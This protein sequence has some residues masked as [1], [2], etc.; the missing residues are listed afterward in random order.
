MQKWTAVVFALLAVAAVA[1]LGTDLVRRRREVSAE[2]FVVRDKAGRVRASLAMKPDGLPELALL[3]ELGRDQVSLSAQVGG[4]TALAFHDRGQ[5]R[6]ALST[7]SDGRANL[8]MHDRGRASSTGLYLHPDGSS[9]IGF[10]E[11]RRGVT[12]SVGPDGSAELRFSDKDGR[13]VGGLGVSA[14][15]EA[16]ELARDDGSDAAVRTLTTP[17][18]SRVGDG[19]PAR[20]ATLQATPAVNTT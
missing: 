1:L 16:R 18:P 5:V 20:S 2:R 4:N 13:L 11:G 15:G 19:K 6:M 10:Q 8:T 17:P 12:M 14:D 9:G 7:G 3:D